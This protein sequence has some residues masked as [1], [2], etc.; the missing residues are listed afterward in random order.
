MKAHA[1]R[2]AGPKKRDTWFLGASRRRVNLAR[3]LHICSGVSSDEGMS[4]D[5]VVDANTL[6]RFIHEQ[7]RQLREETGSW[8]NPTLEGFLLAGA[9]WL[10][11]AQPTKRPDWKDVAILI[12]AMR[13]YE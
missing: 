10:E 8:E 3:S 4:P 11:D 5:E 1:T 13:G 2:Y 12:S 7:V 6:A 9:S